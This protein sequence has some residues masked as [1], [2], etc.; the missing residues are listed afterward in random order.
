MA[1]ESALAQNQ[2]SGTESAS[3]PASSENAG[4]LSTGTSRQ[5]QQEKDTVT[6]SPQ[7]RL[8]HQRQIT[9]S[10]IEGLVTN[11]DQ[12]GIAGV[13]VVLRDGEGKVHEAL[14]NGDGVFRISDL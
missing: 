6:Q 11:E 7:R 14:T 13:R 1:V 10:S 5:D 2:A 8:P 3:L 12:H 4:Q 9:T